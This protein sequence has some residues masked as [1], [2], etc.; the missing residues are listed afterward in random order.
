MYRDRFG[1]VKVVE[2][3]IFYRTESAHEHAYFEARRSRLGDDWSFGRLGVDSVLEQRWLASVLRHVYPLV[4]RRAGV[5]AMYPSGGGGW[6]G[7][8]RPA[9]VASWSG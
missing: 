4:W 5:V 2:K 8:D 3:V 7:M 6:A 9:F 1:C